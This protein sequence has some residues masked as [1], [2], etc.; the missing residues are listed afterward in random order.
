MAEA[1]ATE[2]A[3]K[4]ITIFNCRRLWP[5]TWPQLRTV[6]IPRGMHY[7]R[8]KV[9]ESRTYSTVSNYYQFDGDSIEM[10]V[11]IELLNVRNLFI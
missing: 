6:E 9:F 11:M 8:V 3:Q 5:N 2:I 1:E 10:T 7:C 4:S